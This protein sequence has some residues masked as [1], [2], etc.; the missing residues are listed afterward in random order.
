MM[1]VGRSGHDKGWCSCCRKS[2]LEW[3]THH[4]TNEFNDEWCS[5]FPFWNAQDSV[6]A[7][8]KRDQEIASHRVEGKTE[9]QAFDKFKSSGIKEQC[10]FPFISTTRHALPILHV[11]LGLGNKVIN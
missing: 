10:I 8:T 11:S 6:E 2:K 7:A 9:K 5:D 4:L 1:I 3:T